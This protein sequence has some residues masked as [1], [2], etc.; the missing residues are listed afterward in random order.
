L[1][2]C[3]IDKQVVFILRK[4]DEKPTAIE[5]SRDENAKLTTNKFNNSE[6]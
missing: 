3:S 2:V 5:F 4:H 1:F 6:L